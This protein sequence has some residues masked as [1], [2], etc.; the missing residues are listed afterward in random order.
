MTSSPKLMAFERL[1]LRDSLSFEVVRGPRVTALIPYY[2]V[3]VTCVEMIESCVSEWC[4]HRRTGS[5]I[6]YKYGRISQ[7]LADVLS[8]FMQT[9]CLT[10]TVCC[11]GCKSA[12]CR[13]PPV[14]F[15]V[16]SPD[17]PL[18]HV[19]VGR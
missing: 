17:L 16:C 10:S 6:E 3:A 15:D 14:L 11:R 4:I 9:R 2:S 13:L 12:C 19:N 5:R 8:F 1:K 7:V 18:E